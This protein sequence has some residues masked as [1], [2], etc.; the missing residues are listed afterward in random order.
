MRKNDFENKME[1]LKI[2]NADFIKHQE[3]FKIG[4]LNS[5]KS[6]RIGIILL[7]IPVLFLFGLILRFKI[8]LAINFF[9][10][11]DV[12]IQHLG[13][14]TC[15]NWFISSIILGL[16][17]LGMIINLLAVT[18]FYIDKQRKEFIITF[19]Y[20]LKNIIVFLISIG[21]LIILMAFIFFESTHLK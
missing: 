6:S 21:I 7:L 13:Q 15:L 17:V 2:P 9:V 10:A 8:G 18:H 1:N 19:K 4:L 11:F 14:A 3:I 16:P 12:L 20:R 5:R